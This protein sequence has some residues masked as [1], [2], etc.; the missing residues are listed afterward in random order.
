MIPTFAT[1]YHL[2]NRQPFLSLSD[3]DG[4]SEHSVFQEMLTM[5]RHDLSYRRRYG[6]GYLKTRRLCEDKLR[7]LF[8]ARGGLP[9][10]RHPYYLV[11][12]ESDWFLNLNRD[13]N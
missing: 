8:Q 9:Q 4:D 11:L 1:H 2:S 12:G 3:L 5:H 7:C 13:S 10:R 6:Q